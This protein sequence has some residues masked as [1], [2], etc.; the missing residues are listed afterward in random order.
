MM[1]GFERSDALLP[2]LLRC[3]RDCYLSALLVEEGGSTL[4]YAETDSVRQATLPVD[5]KEPEGQPKTIADGGRRETEQRT[6][7]FWI[8]TN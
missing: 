7:D 5:I 4:L 8:E 1:W 2:S 6:F 3:V